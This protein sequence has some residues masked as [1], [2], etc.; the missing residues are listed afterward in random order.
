[1]SWIRPAAIAA[2]ALQCVGTALA[3]ESSDLDALVLSG[4]LSNSEK[5]LILQHSN[6]A[7]IPGFHFLG[8]DISDPHLFTRFNMLVAP[9]AINFFILSTD[10]LKALGLEKVSCGCLALTQDSVRYIFCNERFL[11]TAPHVIASRL[12]N[13]KETQEAVT[14]GMLQWIVTH[15]IGHHQIRDPRTVNGQTVDAA[16]SLELER[17]AD[18]Y[19][20]QVFAL[21]YLRKP[22]LAAAFSENSPRPKFSDWWNDAKNSLSWVG[23]IGRSHPPMTERVTNFATT[24]ADTYFDG[25]PYRHLSPRI[26][27]LRQ[28]DLCPAQQKTFSEFSINGLLTQYWL[29]GLEERIRL[30]PL[31]QKEVEVSATDE[32]NGRVLKL[33]ACYTSRL[34][35][36]RATCASPPGNDDDPLGTILL[37]VLRIQSNRALG[38][39]T[40]NDRDF[41]LK[42]A[43]NQAEPLIRDFGGHDNFPFF[44][45]LS[46]SSV[47]SV[48]DDCGTNGFGFVHEPS[49]S[50]HAYAAKAESEDLQIDDPKEFALLVNMILALDPTNEIERQAMFHLLAIYSGQN[51]KY[52]TQPVILQA[53]KKLAL[54]TLSS[55]HAQL[56]ASL[57]MIYMGF[58]RSSD[59]TPLLIQAVEREQKTVPKR[60]WAA[61]EIMVYATLCADHFAVSCALQL[62]RRAAE[63]ADKPDLD[64]S[65]SEIAGLKQ[66]KESADFGLA[67]ML[68]WTDDIPGALRILNQQLA[69]ATDAE[70]R[71]AIIET[72]AEAYIWNGDGQAASTSLSSAAALYSQVE[73]SDQN[74]WSTL[75]YQVAAS[76]LL[77]QWALAARQ[78]DELDAL[79]EKIY[80]V[81]LSAT[82]YPFAV[83]HR[84]IRAIELKSGVY[85]NAGR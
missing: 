8:N 54:P 31:L 43:A 69:T 39:S 7:E 73:R 41:L 10:Q 72:I 61:G 30:L 34:A 50:C 18:A 66:A 45:Y 68:I 57:G 85:R 25:R 64:A 27:T 33:M 81:A 76:Y 16:T 2:L 5:V 71:I 47:D 63:V 70:S 37:A 36:N 51:N 75:T 20:A 67:Q 84:F 13:D 28:I 79:H 52:G 49:A 65:E 32:A 17:R 53:M 46:W 38:L 56:I 74:K 60:V 19:A 15:E 24:V 58:G 59:A 9:E 23:D 55:G 83:N 40:G 77:N 78:L 62:Y 29:Y 42:V 48:L 3:F 44:H 82:D 14:A 4:A 12:S 1:M 6:T 11:A 80:A 35:G 26:S 22:F 21:T